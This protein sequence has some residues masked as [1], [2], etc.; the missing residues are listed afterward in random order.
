MAIWPYKIQ[1]LGLRAYL[2]I[3]TYSELQGALEK[4]E[5]HPRGTLD[6]GVFFDRYVFGVFELPMQRNIQKT[7]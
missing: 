1:G 3:Y 5:K 2:C 7:Q 6:L 4:K